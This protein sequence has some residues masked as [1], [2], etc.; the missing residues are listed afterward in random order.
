MKHPSSFIL[1]KRGVL[2]GL[3]ERFVYC[4]CKLIRAG[5]GLHAAPDPADTLR[6]F[7][8]LHAFAELADSLEVA[9]AA[10]IELE[11]VYPPVIIDIEPDRPGAGSMR[12]IL[13]CFHLTL[14]RCKIQEDPEEG[15]MRL[16]RFEAEDMAEVHHLFH[17]SVHELA[18]QFYTPQQLA[19]WAPDDADPA[20]WGER[21]LD[22][23]SAVAEED[24]RILGFGSIDAPSGYVDMLYV[25]P[26]AAG[27]GVGKT[28]LRALEAESEAQRRYSFVS[29]A[30]EGFFRHMGYAPLRLNTAERRGIVLEN[31]LME[32]FR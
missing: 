2:S 25:L 15:N 22:Q 3:A 29:F 7:L 21:F 14:L 13:D 28:L 26:S 31:L 4:S 17:A 11:A 10:A 27:H 19:A 9:I 5:C 8:G 24:G 1:R 30:A 12:S 16:R 6:D 18:G 20:E 23:Y 32:R